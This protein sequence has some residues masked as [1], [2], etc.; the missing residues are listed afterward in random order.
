MSPSRSILAALFICI[1]VAPLPST[2]SAPVDIDLEL[3]EVEEVD[4]AA[5]GVGCAGLP[6]GEYLGGTDQIA[7]VGYPAG[8]WSRVFDVTVRHETSTSFHFTMGMEYLYNGTWHHAAAHNPQTGHPAYTASRLHE[9]QTYRLNWDFGG[10]G[11]GDVAVRI[12]LDPEDEILETDEGNNVWETAAR[13][14]DLDG[15]PVLWNLNGEAAEDGTVLHDPFYQ[16]MRETDGYSIFYASDLVLSTSS[17]LIA[18]ASMVLD[19]HAP[20]WRNIL[21]F[22]VRTYNEVYG[23]VSYQLCHG[24]LP[25]RSC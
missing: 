5:N 19:E 1:L 13:P 20:G 22:L 24:G 6:W 21:P 10:V 25:V 16:G 7:C 8:A 4:L 2:A 14:L 12:T 18:E 11:L 9:T 17:A 3:V 23:V 15:E